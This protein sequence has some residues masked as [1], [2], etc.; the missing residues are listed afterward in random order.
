MHCVC[1]LGAAV[2]IITDSGKRII[3]TVCSVLCLYLYTENKGLLFLFF[4]NPNESPKL[5]K[6]RQCINRSAP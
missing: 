5:G 2:D 1:F 4:R 3:D 6:G